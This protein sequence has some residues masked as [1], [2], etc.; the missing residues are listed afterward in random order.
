MDLCD[1]KQLLKEQGLR[2]TRSRIL[3][4]EAVLALQSPEPVHV[5]HEI[6]ARKFPLDLATVYRNLNLLKRVGLVREL[7]NDGGMRYFEGACSHHPLH[8]HL[9]C[10]ECG[11]VECQ[12]TETLQKYLEVLE[13]PAGFLVESVSFRITGLCPDCAGGTK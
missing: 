9:V 1:A 4:L 5:I 6:V 7:Y 3:T 11:S 10:R 8:P 2:A 12:S 13:Y